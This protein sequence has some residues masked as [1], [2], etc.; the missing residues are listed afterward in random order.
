[1]MCVSGMADQYI[2]GPPHS[3]NAGRP[4]N[5]QLYAADTRIH[6]AEITEASQRRRTTLVVA[7]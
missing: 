3:Y 4:G 5:A 6:S 1:M 7:R 2:G